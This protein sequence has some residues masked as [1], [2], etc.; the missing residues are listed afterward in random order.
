MKRK[1]VKRLVLDAVFCALIAILSFVPYVGFIPL[2]FTTVTDVHVVVIIG[3]ILLGPKDGL[4]LGTFM[5][6]CSMIQGI[7]SPTDPF[8]YIFAFPWVSILPRAAF[9][10]IAGLLATLFKRI[11][12]NKSVAIGLT[13][14]LST[15]AHTLLVYIFFT[16]TYLIYNKIPVTEMYD[17]AI[18]NNWSNVSANV[19]I[20]I[21]ILFMFNSLLESI[22]AVLVS[23][24]IN[25][26]IE[27]AY[28]EE[29]FSALKTK[30][31]I[32]SEENEEKE[33]VSETS[34]EKAE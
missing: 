27:A 6:I 2:G 17:Y 25:R 9:G 16:P 19:V 33:D 7:G 24:P 15:I 23:T 3:A 32:V 26:A 10:F 4:I 11:I 12:P 18:V 20:W 30:K 31:E 29:F 13:A 22:L 14:G 1:N 5:G 28:G 21:F 34:G 8:N